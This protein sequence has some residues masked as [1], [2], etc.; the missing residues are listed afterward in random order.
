M[1][2]LLACLTSPQEYEALVAIA[3]DADGDGVASVEYG[4]MD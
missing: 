3:Q 1:L 4:G 2:L